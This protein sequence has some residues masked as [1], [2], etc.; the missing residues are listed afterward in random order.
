MDVKFAADGALAPAVDQDATADLGPFLHVCE[1][2]G[3]SKHGPVKKVKRTFIV[4]E[5]LGSEP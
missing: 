5:L 2:P 1:H 4:A 3:A